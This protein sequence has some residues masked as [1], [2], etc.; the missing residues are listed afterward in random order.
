MEEAILLATS[1]PFILCIIFK[2]KSIAAHRSGLKT[3]IIPKDNTKDIDDIPEEVRNALEIIPVEN[4][5]DVFQ[6][7]LK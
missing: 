1:S 4:V 6:I 7:A 5:N 2:E 3:I